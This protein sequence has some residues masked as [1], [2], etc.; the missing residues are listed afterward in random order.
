MSYT[1]PMR[2]NMA[3]KIEFI[4]SLKADVKIS[5]DIP[6]GI[7]DARETSKVFNADVTYATAI[8]KECLFA[9]KY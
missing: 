8:A 2:P 6:A 1:P 3:E 5:I 4:N 9:T 7:S